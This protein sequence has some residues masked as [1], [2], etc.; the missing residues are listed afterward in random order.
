M[1]TI[2]FNKKEN[3]ISMTRMPVEDDLIERNSQNRCWFRSKQ[4]LQGVIL[5][6]TIAVII[7]FFPVIKH[8]WSISPQ[9][10][11][12]RYHYFF[13]K[14]LINKYLPLQSSSTLFRNT[15]TTTRNIKMTPITMTKITNTTS[16]TPTTTTKISTTTNTTPT[17]TTTTPITTTTTPTTTATTPTTTIT[18][19]TAT[20]TTSTAT[21]TT[22]TTKHDW[23]NL[24]NYEVA[25]QQRLD[26]SK[27]IIV[28]EKIYD[29]T[30]EKAKSVCEDICGRLYL[31]TTLTEN[32]S[33][34]LRGV[35]GHP[36]YNVDNNKEDLSFLNF[37][38]CDNINS[39]YTREHHAMLDWMGDWWSKAGNMY[40]SQF[41]LCELT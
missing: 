8:K 7:V 18:T 29:N 36:I 22:S 21:T 6:I 14:S 3:E 13:Y 2:K 10:D 24:D 31:P 37:D 25:L 17:T 28:V 23:C 39:T 15:S 40:H 4:K 30:Y 19:S 32:E 34:R 26:S 5:V 33:L 38:P 1:V 12:E 35:D 9:F 20:I 16:K 27:D 11:D 41:V